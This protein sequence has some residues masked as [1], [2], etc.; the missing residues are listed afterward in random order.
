[1]TD[2]TKPRNQYNKVSEL[3][4]QNPGT[5][6][7]KQGRFRT[8]TTTAEPPREGTYPQN[9]TDTTKVRTA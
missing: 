1:G 3:I 6:T 4:Q 8:N 7:T 2:T 5:N 9:G